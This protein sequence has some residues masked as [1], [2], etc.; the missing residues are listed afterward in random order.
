MS[1]EQPVGVLHLDIQL[2]THLRV[3][4]IMREAYVAASL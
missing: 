4:R 1:C 2:R 3:T